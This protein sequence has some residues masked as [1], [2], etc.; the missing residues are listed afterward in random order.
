MNT[1]GFD[2]QRIRTRHETPEGTAPLRDAVDAFTA[3]FQMLASAA[4]TVEEPRLV[5]PSR[6]ST[7]TNS[8]MRRVLAGPTEPGSFIM[9]IWVPIPPP[10]T[11]YEDAVLFDPDGDPAERIATRRLYEALTATRRAGRDVLDDGAGIEAF[12]ER[13]EFGVS[14]NL[15][16]SLVEL[17]GQSRTPFD[18]GFSWALS[19]PMRDAPQDVSFERETLDVLEQAATE[20]GSRFLR[21]RL[22]C[23]AA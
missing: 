15:C 18:V 20:L 4:A 1:L 5:L 17:G 9:S 22:E 14:A 12:E 8:L 19:R 2:I 21:T 11:P 10:L 3:A 7:T 13:A 16:E 23:A 6:R